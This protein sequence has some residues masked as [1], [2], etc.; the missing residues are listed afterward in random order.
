M[1]SK[2]LKKIQ[3]I[4]IITSP[5]KSNKKVLQGADSNHT[6]YTINLNNIKKKTKQNT[7]Q[8]HITTKN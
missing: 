3:I 4:A 2:Q 7:T 6:E 1:Y 5:I 8:K